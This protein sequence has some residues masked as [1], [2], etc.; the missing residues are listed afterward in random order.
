MSDAVIA[1]DR[2]ADGR[3]RAARLANGRLEDLLIDPPPGGDPALPEALFSARIDRLAPGLGAAFARIG[4]EATAFL[5][6]A[7]GLSE[8]D[9]LILQIVSHPEPG[10]A[11]PA[12]RRVLYKTR[13]VIVTPDAPGVNLS[14]R[15]RDAAIRARL[16]AEA[17]AALAAAG[18][19]DGAGLILR[20]AAET[21]A[22]EAIAA[23]IAAAL[24]AWA[25]VGAAFAADTTP[26]LLRPA[27]AAAE[28]ALR[29]W[30]G[31]PGGSLAETGVEDR[32]DSL[33][34]A[35]IALGGGHWMAVE[36]TRALTGVDVNTGE[37]FGGDAA[38]AANL[39]AARDLP[40]Q[41]RLRGLG[42]V[43]VVDFAPL[44]KRARRRVEDALKTS[45]ARDP[46]E[47]SLAGWTTLGLFEI[48]R[49]RERRPLRPGRDF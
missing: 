46:V 14:R 19:G 31:R 32:L 12:T 4:P 7:R 5:R 48:Q 22:P 42:G 16:Q 10:K 43:I 25:E 6:D 26:R 20:S 11:P 1:T 37:G 2:L 44:P 45:F 18:G 29:D 23:D 49:K 15:I 36:P 27:P 9:R 13:S 40:R 41:L 3:S 39:A 34:T 38:L 35:E 24:A 8:G 21:A 33:A 28:L 30:D 47:T 17:E